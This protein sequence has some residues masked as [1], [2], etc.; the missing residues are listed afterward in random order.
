MNGEEDLK[1][2][3]KDISDDPLVAEINHIER[4]KPRLAFRCKMSLVSRFD[5]KQFMEGSP[6][7]PHKVRFMV[8][9]SAFVAATIIALA[10]VIFAGLTVAAQDS[11][12]GD[13]LYAFKRAKEALEMAFASNPSSKAAKNIALAERRL[14]ELEKVVKSDSVSSNTVK[15]LAD[16]FKQN[17]RAAIETI[18]AVSGKQE[19]ADL[20]THLS[21]LDSEK[22]TILS[23]LSLGS[24][25]SV[26]ASGA[27]LTVRDSS[28]SSS[29]NGNQRA[30]VLATDDSGQSTIKLQSG[31]RDSTKDLEV[32]VQQGNRTT[33]AP[34]V[35]VPSVLKDQSG[36]FQ[37]SIS[38]VP[39]AIS[40]NTPC[41]FTLNVTRTDGYPSGPL[42]VLVEDTVGGDLLNGGSVP[43][44]LSPDSEGN[45]V[46]TLT[47]TSASV[48]KLVVALDTGGARLPV[49]EILRVGGTRSPRAPGVPVSVTATAG[50]T[51]SGKSI[52][53]LNNGLVTV[54]ASGDDAGCVVSSLSQSGGGQSVGPLSDTVDVGQSGTFE[55]KGPSLVSQS[56]L[57][58]TYE[59]THT[60]SVAE[61]SV[62]TVYDV[63]L[64]SGAKHVVIQRHYS[65]QGQ[66]P[67]GLLTPRTLML[68]RSSSVEVGTKV[69]PQQ[70]PVTGR[71]ILPFNPVSPYAVLTSGG[72][73]VALMFPVVAPLDWVVKGNSAGVEFDPSTADITAVLGYCDN[74][75]ASDLLTKARNNPA[76]SLQTAGRPPAEGFSV[77]FTSLPSSGTSREIVVT[78]RKQFEKWTDY[79]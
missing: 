7:G 69:L 66:P 19:A 2:T 67:A 77:T 48:S 37:V 46:L 76:T 60:L 52:V 50:T 35:G 49:G 75:S 58:S 36:R 1:K 44:R 55:T 4:L 8:A 53:T 42:G 5:V 30:A 24:A 72:A 65:V 68:P 3:I 11:R 59:I 38:P 12:P 18:A 15:Y 6:T 47:K 10:V 70:T 20:Y 40:V 22:D 41:E 62:K 27:M 56:A 32:E 39:Q 31:A 16:Q 33:V 43:V 64:F 78:V 79:F 9:R 74:N 57:S 54:V 29:L 13:P 63:Q 45:C 26:P 21:S 61:G 71:Q 17:K 14:A 34:L 28:G 25:A 73:R 51:P 23:K